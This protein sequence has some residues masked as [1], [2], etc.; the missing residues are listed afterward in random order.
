MAGL[1]EG[2]NEPPGSLKAS[3]SQDG[4]QCR[5]CPEIETLPHILGFCQH[6]TLVQNTRWNAIREL[7]GRSLPSFY[8]VHQ[9]AHCLGKDESSRRVDIIAIDK[10][11]TEQLSSIPP[12]ALK[13]QLNNL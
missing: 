11:M 2:G 9:D 3:R 13:L 4:S 6:G 12:C 7:F 10:E 1:C 8:K 5:H